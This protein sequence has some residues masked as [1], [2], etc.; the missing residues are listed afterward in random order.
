M[1]IPDLQFKI[2]SATSN[3]TVPANFVPAGKVLHIRVNGVFARFSWTADT[4]LTLDTPAP[5][6]ALLDFAV[7][8]SVVGDVIVATAALN[9]GSVA[10]QSTLDKSTQCPGAVV[11]DPV[12]IGTSTAWPA[13][14]TFSA[15]VFTN[16]T[17]QVRC[18]NYTGAA[19]DPPN[20]N[21]RLA[22]LR[23]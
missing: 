10:A 14:V 15:G 2:D 16:G 5:A 19:I 6:G 9:Y 22:V 17:I 18:H 11:G 8:D 4:T 7:E 13:G 21:F 3:F 23:S 1:K 20:I 12:A